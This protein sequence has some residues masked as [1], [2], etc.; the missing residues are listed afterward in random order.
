ME[1]DPSNVTGE[2]VHRHAFEHRVNW[3]HV[4]L[5]LAAVLVAWRVFSVASDGSDVRSGRA[6]ESA[7]ETVSGVR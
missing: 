1:P 6:S 3:G 5:A 4:A 7:S 2:V